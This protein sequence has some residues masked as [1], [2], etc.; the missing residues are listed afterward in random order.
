MLQK[1]LQV[2]VAA[3]L[4]ALVVTLAYASLALQGPD[5]A[6]AG[7]QAKAARGELARAIAE[8]GLAE[9]DCCGCAANGTRGS[10]ATRKRWPTSGA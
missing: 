9:H 10:A 6:I 7:A 3:A 1:S 8:L 5:E 2:L 4:A